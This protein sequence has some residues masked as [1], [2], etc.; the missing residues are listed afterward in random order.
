MGVAGWLAWS[1]TPMPWAVVAFGRQTIDAARPV[2]PGIV[3]EDVPRGPG[4][5]DLSCTYV[6]EGTNVS[7]AVTETKR[8]RAELPRRRQDPG[9]D[10]ARRHAAPADAGA[11]LRPWSTRSPSRSWSWPAA[12]ASPPAAFVAA[13]RRQADRHLRHRAAGADQSWRR[14]SARRITTSSTASPARTPTRSTAS[15]SRWSTTTAGTSSAPPARSS[16]SSPP[17]RSTPGSRAAPR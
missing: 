13:P 6:G 16:T 10:P 5:P 15:R 4:D 12:R 7:V 8:G 14:C 1:V 17:T 3:K 11:H 9:V 2:G